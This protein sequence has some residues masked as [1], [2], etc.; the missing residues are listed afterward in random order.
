LAE[1]D[2]HDKFSDELLQSIVDGI[3]TDKEETETYQKYIQAYK[4]AMKIKEEKLNDFF[5][6]LGTSDFKCLIQ[7][8]VDN[9]SITLRLGNEHVLFQDGQ[10]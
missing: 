3:R 7:T 10:E 5:E 6:R 1:E 9:G 2:K 4:K 8:A